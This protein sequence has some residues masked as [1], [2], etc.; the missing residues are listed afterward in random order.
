M[1]RFCSLFSGSNGNSLFVSDGK[2]RILVDAGVSGIRIKKAL[3]SIGEDFLNIDAVLVT[4]EHSDHSSCVGVVSRWVKYQN[5][6]VYATKGTWY[7]MSRTVGNINEASKNYIKA[8]ETFQIGDITIKPFSIPHDA[9]DP[10]GYSFL[11]EGKKLTI[12][13]DIGHMNDSLLENIRNSDLL[14]LESNHDLEML[15]NGPYPYVLKR[16]IKSEHGHL[17]NSLAGETIANLALEGVKKFIIGHLSGENNRPDLALDTVGAC[18]ESAGL[19]IGR[20]IELHVAMRGITS[21]VFYI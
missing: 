7:G 18:I 6:P 5:I 17:C 4:H 16:R 20:D 13:T 8:N 19:R 2:T 9:A 11:C 3:C 10:V 12:A 15:E 1:F 21:E 14:M